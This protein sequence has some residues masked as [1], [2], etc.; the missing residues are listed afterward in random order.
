M[1]AI[2]E[3]PPLTIALLGL[4]SC[5]LLAL[6]LVLLPS[7]VLPPDAG[8]AAPADAKI[9]TRGDLLQL[10]L[11]SYAA[12]SERPLFN[13]GRRKDPAQALAD[14]STPTGLPGLDTYRLAGIVIS[15]A[16]RLALV[17]RIAS[18]QIVSVKPGD[19]LDGRRVEDV[20]ED[21]V[22]FSG[23]GGVETL[24]MPHVNGWSRTD[25]TTAAASAESPSIK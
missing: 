19:T 24:S 8:I 18:K 22:V 5:A 14:A 12:I 20:E 15:S 4:A 25:G 16:T 11:A 2:A 21:N 7:L 3:R 13:E 23:A 6:V 17:E 1:T 9:L 10:P